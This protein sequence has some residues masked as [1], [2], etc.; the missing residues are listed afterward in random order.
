M[1]NRTSLVQI[2]SATAVVLAFVSCAPNDERSFR[3]KPN[4]ERSADALRAKNAA[5]EKARK[6]AAA[7]AAAEQAKK[8]AAAGGGSG[9][10]GAGTGGAAGGAGAGQG[11]GAGTGVTATGT[12]L[13]GGVVTT[14]TQPANRTADP[15]KQAAVQK[16]FDDL[17]KIAT[18]S[19]AADAIKAIKGVS[20][21]VTLLTDK[22]RDAKACE[23][24]VP[25]LSIEVTAV[26][27]IR[28]DI[29]KTSATVIVKLADGKAPFEILEA[30]VLKQI[31]LSEIAGASVKLL[32]YDEKCNELGLIY[33]ATM[34]GKT[35][36]EIA[37]YNFEPE[38]PLSNGQFTPGASTEM[39]LKTE[40]NGKLST[41]VAD[42]G[43][44][45]FSQALE[46]VSSAQAA[47]DLEMQTRQR[48]QALENERALSAR[49]D[50]VTQLV[51]K[52][53]A[54]A[55]AT[56]AEKVLPV[57]AGISASLSSAKGDDCKPA[58][59]AATAEGAA[60]I[61]KDTLCFRIDVQANITVDRVAI[62]GVAR[63][64]IILQNGLMPEDFAPLVIHNRADNKKIDEFKAK[65]VCVDN[66]CKQVYIAFDAP[67]KV[68]YA[69]TRSNDIEV[70][71][72]NFKKEN[73]LIV[74][75]IGPAAKTFSEALVTA[76][77]AGAAAPAAPGTTPGS[78]G[79]A[80]VPPAAPRP[81]APATTGPAPG[82]A[83][84]I[85]LQD[86]PR[87]PMGLGMALWCGLTRG[88][89]DGCGETK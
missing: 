67:V 38:K 16:Q 45:Y 19:V 81:A 63:R 55:R 28:T 3:T 72:L 60:T 78:A 42:V 76:P 49:E 61:D 74:S 57:I 8:D 85:S 37:A 82:T 33:Y 11:A 25:C 44:K 41:T 14:P 1:A 6:E 10:A 39:K 50:K 69:F 86:A 26:L 84:P 4:P 12:S 68:V 5:D 88:K 75:S 27:G 22:L 23:N 65:V 30:K 24:V 18:E 83:S 59:P 56:T 21:S 36:P 20:V 87:E 32:C 29:T 15:A 46:P 53:M 35:T 34:E 52:E 71:A 66:E 70:K 58:N 17:L 7:A 40:A 73:D 2:L 62:A 64:R 31:E 79:A 47:A 54:E 77:A 43:F 9:G 80:A 13:G 89:A 51:N 48:A